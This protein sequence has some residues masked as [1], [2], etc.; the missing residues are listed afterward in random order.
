MDIV[1]RRNGG[2]LLVGCAIRNVFGELLNENEVY[3]SENSW[4]GKTTNGG[5]CIESSW[6]KNFVVP[7]FRGKV[8]KASSPDEL[9]KLKHYKFFEDEKTDFSKW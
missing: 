5:V 6:E 7:I 4:W 3:S 1:T 9:R 2:S 8:I